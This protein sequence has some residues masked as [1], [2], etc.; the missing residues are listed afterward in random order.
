MVKRIC[1]IG[2]PGSGKSTFAKKLAEKT[3]IPIVHLDQLWWKENWIEST[4]EEFISKLKYELEKESW[5][6]DGNYSSTLKMRCAIAD[7]LYV[8]DL[9]KIQSLF[10]YIKRAILNRGRSRADMPNNCVEKI[11]FEFMKYIWNFKLDDLKSLE[12]EFPHLK[13]IVMKS[14][15]DAEKILQ[16]VK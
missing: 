5:I 15:K 4:K 16:S 13:V 1:I 6:M 11:E 7:I 3:G 10:G 12:E 9:P 14:H 8:Y 2:R